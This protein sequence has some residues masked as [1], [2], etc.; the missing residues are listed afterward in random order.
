MGSF[1]AD[2]E[3]VTEVVY[4]KFNEDGSVND[5]IEQNK[6]NE[7]DVEDEKKKIKN[8]RTVIFDGDH[9]GKIY[10]KFTKIKAKIDRLEDMV[11]VLEKEDNIAEI[12]KILNKYSKKNIYFY[13]EENFFGR[14]M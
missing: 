6:L 7:D 13:I 4:C 10:N 3:N 2:G 12:E 11:E 9:F 8:F 5:V 14:Q 1:D